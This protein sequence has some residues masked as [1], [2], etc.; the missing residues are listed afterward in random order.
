MRR[1]F[2]YNVSEV[3]AGLMPSTYRSKSYCSQMRKNKTSENQTDT[4]NPHIL[5]YRGVTVENMSFTLRQADTGE[6]TDQD[7]CFNRI[8]VSVVLGTLPGAKADVR[9]SVGS[10]LQ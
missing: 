3:R 5:A 7:S 8:P 10:L 1:K 9:R 2:K 4:W 6:R